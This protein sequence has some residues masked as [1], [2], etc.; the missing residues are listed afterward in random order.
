MGRL[1][2]VRNLQDAPTPS[3]WPPQ[4]IAGTATNA[5]KRTGASAKN[6]GIPGSEEASTF[7]WSSRAY[8]SARASYNARTGRRCKACADGCEISGS[9]SWTV[10]IGG[11]GG[12]GVGARTYGRNSR[13][14]GGSCRD[15][16]GGRSWPGASRL[17]GSWRSY[18]GYRSRGGATRAGT[19]P[20]ARGSN[21]CSGG[22]G[23]S[24]GSLGADGCGGPRRS[25]RREGRL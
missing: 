5:T 13:G 16:G 18:G 12:S 9:C 22:E 10:G 19:T 21:G 8:R 11:A 6:R 3:R 20:L 15:L 1:E 25:G 17:R 2:L 7:L 24:G 14:G 4:P 23:G